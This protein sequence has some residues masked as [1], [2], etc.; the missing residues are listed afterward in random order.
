MNNDF[1]LT[2]LLKENELFFL[3]SLFNIE[4][5]RNANVFLILFS[6]YKYLGFQRNPRDML[7]QFH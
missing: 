7:T 5:V 1:T 3:H 2:Y 4:M 6:F